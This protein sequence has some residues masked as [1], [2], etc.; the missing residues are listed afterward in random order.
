MKKLNRE[1]L[2]LIKKA[3]KDFYYNGYVKCVIKCTCV[4][5]YSNKIITTHLHSGNTCQYE[6]SKDDYNYLELEKLSIKHNK[7]TKITEITNTF[8]DNVFEH[9]PELYSMVNISKLTDT[10]GDIVDILLE[11]D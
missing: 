9:N 6:L 11:I 1:Q 2:D 8:I 7:K 10:I 4:E 5:I 3:S